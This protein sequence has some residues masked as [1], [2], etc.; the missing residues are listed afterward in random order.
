MFVECKGDFAGIKARVFHDRVVTLPAQIF[1]NLLKPYR[2]ARSLSFE[3]SLE[4]PSWFRPQMD[5]FTSDAQAWDQ[6][7]PAIPKY[8]KY[9]PMA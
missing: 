4:D 1:R 5:T 8:E 2:G 6:M 9:P 3:G 7:D